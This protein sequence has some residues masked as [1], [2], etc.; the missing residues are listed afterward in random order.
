MFP[1]SNASIL[2]QAAFVRQRSNSAGGALNAR[3]PKLERMLTRLWSPRCQVTAMAPGEVAAWPMCSPP[4][5]RVR[6][7]GAVATLMGGRLYT[8]VGRG[9]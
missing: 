8:G 2:A 6:F 5:L 9:V 4:G 1:G 3:Q 7:C